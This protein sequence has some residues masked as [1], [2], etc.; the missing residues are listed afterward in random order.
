L[1]HLEEIVVLGSL[2]LKWLMK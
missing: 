1:N 2:L